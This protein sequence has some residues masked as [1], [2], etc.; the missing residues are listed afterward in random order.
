MPETLNQNVEE[1]GF[2]D[3]DL[4][5]VLKNVRDIV[6]ELQADHATFKTVTDDLKTLLNS[7][8]NTLAGDAVLG[9]AALAQGSTPANVANSAFY[10]LIN[11]VL[12]LKAAVAAGTAPGN[13]VVP[14]NKYGAV[15][16]DIGADGTIDAVEATDN[17]TGYNSAVLA[18]AA[19]PA[20]ASDHVR[21][22]YVTAMKSDGNFTFGTTDLAA[23]NT[24]VAYT[25]TGSALASVG[26]A[27]SSSSP[28]SL[29]NSTAITLNKG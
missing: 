8:R 11:G 23:A 10:Y 6:N 20:V 14:Q 28:A 25:D 2:W 24:T 3:G 12:Y 26:A 5:K 16:L 17:A 21:M 18:A 1:G 19:L 27:V 7:V 15:A 22:G 9:D 29:T 13:D 4:V